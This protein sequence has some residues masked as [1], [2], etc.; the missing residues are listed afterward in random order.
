MVLWVYKYLYFMRVLVLMIY[1]LREVLFSLC[2]FQ[3]E[4][5]QIVLVNNLYVYDSDHICHHRI[6]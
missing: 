5:T 1:N 2:N 6:C 4:H 3:L